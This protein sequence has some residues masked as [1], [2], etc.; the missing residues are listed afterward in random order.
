MNFHSANFVSY[1]I[2]KCLKP[3]FSPL[4]SLNYGCKI[5]DDVL[6]PIWFQTISLPSSEQ[7][8]DANSNN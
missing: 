7:L 5:T 3:C 8:N 2:S 1:T 6:V 4:N